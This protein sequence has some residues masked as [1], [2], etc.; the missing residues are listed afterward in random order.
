MKVLVELRQKSND[1]LQNRLTQIALSLR[2]TMS[3]NT[4][5][6]EVSSRQGSGTNTMYIG[7]LRRERARIL[8]ILNER[9]KSKEKLVVSKRGLALTTLDTKVEKE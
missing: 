2:R 5:S 1:Q 6:S 8:T 4:A 9:A 3:K 7:N